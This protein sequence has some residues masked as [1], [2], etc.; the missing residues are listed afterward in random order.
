MIGLGAFEPFL[1]AGSAGLAVTAALVAIGQFARVPR[2]LVRSRLE[3][4]HGRSPY[5]PQAIDVLRDRRASRL[6]LA[7]FLQGRRSTQEIRRALE[8]AGLDLRI[9][10]YLA[11]RLLAIVAGT[12]GG[13]LA[14]TSISRSV[15]LLLAAMGGVA[16]ALLPSLLLRRR[17]AKRRAAIERELVEMCELMSS[18]L[19]SGFG[20]LQALNTAAEQVEE[21]LAGELVRMRDA[22]RVGAGVD[23]SLEQ[24]NERLASRDFDMVTTAIIIQRRSGGSL[25]EIL[26]GVA[27]TIRDRSLFRA[28]VAALTSRERYSAILMAGFPLVLTGFLVLMAPAVFGRLISD[29]TGRIILGVALTTDLMGYLA[30]RRATKLEV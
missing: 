18:M 1:I 3:A 6:P 7:D 4:A 24:L 22:I 30:I 11:L 15:W 25:A 10:E 28:E 12:G 26:S 21:P 20:Y 9:G 17:I 16:G 14:A 29:P 19:Q 8:Q 27:K 13:Y 23:E 2:E 5:T